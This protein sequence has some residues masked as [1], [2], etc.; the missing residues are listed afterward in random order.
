MSVRGTTGVGGG[1]VAGCPSASRKRRMRSAS[2][3][4][5]TR[6]IGSLARGAGS[7]LGSGFCAFFFG[8]PVLLASNLNNAAIAISKRKSRFSKW[9]ASML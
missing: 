3:S 8:W 4:F 7:D 6:L 9:T 1:D 5:G 2:V